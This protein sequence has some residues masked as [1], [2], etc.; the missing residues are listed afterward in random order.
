MFFHG[1]DCRR[2]QLVK[3]CTDYRI[4]YG[5]GASGVSAGLSHRSGYLPGKCRRAGERSSTG[6]AVERNPPM[7]EGG[8]IRLEGLKFAYQDAEPLLKGINFFST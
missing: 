8:H 1:Y 4:F 3:F 6:Q 7:S 2:N 5:S